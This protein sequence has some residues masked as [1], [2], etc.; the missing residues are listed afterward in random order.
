LEG[1]RGICPTIAET[2][3][4]LS[5]ILELLA[6]PFP[7]LATVYFAISSSLPQKR[8]SKYYIG[9]KQKDQLFFKSPKSDEI[10]G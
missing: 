7:E 4:E 8:T 10:N 3:F 9:L 2:P 6:Y 5:R 1:A